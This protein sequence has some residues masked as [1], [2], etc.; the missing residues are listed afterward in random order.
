MIVHGSMNYTT[1][2]RKMKSAWQTRRRSQV[3]HWQST[4][5]TDAPKEPVYRR[6]DVK[7][8]S[9]PLGDPNDDETAKK[10][11]PY[12]GSSTHT[13]APAYNKGA[14]QVITNEN[15]KDIGR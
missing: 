12:V 9:L 10:D 4:D 11:R 2:G 3:W 8:P 14:Y 6:T 5:K 13:I 1:D 7:Y 15:I